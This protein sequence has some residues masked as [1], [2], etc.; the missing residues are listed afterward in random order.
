MVDPFLDAALHLDLLEP[1]DVVGCRPGVWRAGYKLV[2]LL[3]G[4]VV[5]LLDAVYPH[6]VEEFGMIHDVF[7]ESVAVLIHEVDTHV[8]I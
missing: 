5:A 7:L 3:L 2:K 8:G 6:P 1:V 4:V